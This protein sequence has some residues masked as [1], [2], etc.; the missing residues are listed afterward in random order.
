MRAYM[1]EKN[2]AWNQWSEIFST[3]KVIFL[4]A[5]V[6]IFLYYLNQ[7]IGFF[8][9]NDYVSWIF[10]PA[11]VRLLSVLLFG[12]PGVAGLFLG[13]LVTTIPLAETKVALLMIPAISS[14]SPYIAVWVCLKLMR[15]GRNLQNLTGA[16]LLIMAF[17]TASLSSL[18]H[19]IYF[20]YNGE[21]VFLWRMLIGD[22]I[23]SLFILYMAKALLNR[24][25]RT[26]RKLVHPCQKGSS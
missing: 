19:S 15:T 18:A 3:V 24:Y 5:V 2:G 8:Y 1:Q 23:G 16:Q 14:I 22:F 4:V 20:Y 11:T 12:G 9:L 10:F 25:S 17:A 13:C 6:W 26:R 21:P 7:S